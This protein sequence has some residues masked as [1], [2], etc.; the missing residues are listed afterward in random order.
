MHLHSD[1]VWNVCMLCE[2]C[3]KTYILLTTIYYKTYILLTTIYF[4]KIWASDFLGGWPQ[5]QIYILRYHILHTWTGTMI[6]LTDRLTTHLGTGGVDGVHQSLHVCP[7][8][9][10][11]GC[12]VPRSGHT[13]R[14]W[15][16]YNNDNKTSFHQWNNKQRATVITILT[17]ILSK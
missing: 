12:G 14:P 1:I 10:S 2:M 9:S 5:N 17:L 11:E 7:Q 3:Y 15:A 13:R 8:R 6:T 16:P 4:H